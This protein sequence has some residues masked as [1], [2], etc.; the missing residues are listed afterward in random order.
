MKKA[1]NVRRA[2][3]TCLDAAR[4]WAEIEDEFVPNLRAWLSERTL[5]FYLVRKTRLVGKRALQMSLG[6]LARDLGLTKNPVRTALWRLAKKGAVR[7]LDRGHYGHRIEVKVPREIPGC[8]TKRPRAQTKQKR[9]SLTR[10]REFRRAI[11]EREGHRCFYCLRQLHRQ[12]RVLDHVR[13]R[14][15]GGSDAYWNLVACCFACNSMKRDATA[16][17]FLRRLVREDLINRREFRRRM[18]ALEALKLGK[19]KPELPKAA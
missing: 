11:F 13:P 2:Q 1:Q 17:D 19:L 7:V 10:S 3:T 5:Y 15:R 6:D 18:A 9:E 14:I 4:L 8:L 12:S 16:E